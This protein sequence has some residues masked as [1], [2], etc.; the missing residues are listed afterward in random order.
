MPSFEHVGWLRQSQSS[1][2]RSSF[3]FITVV[4]SV[5]CSREELMIDIEDDHEIKSSQLI[6]FGGLLEDNQ[7][8]SL[9][10]ET[11]AWIWK[12]IIDRIVSCA[13]ICS[14]G[15]VQFYPL[16]MLFM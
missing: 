16:I 7:L 3:I 4:L 10:M 14:H 8:Y 9:N 13:I 5:S 15:R 11:L 12:G 2:L 6:V 1:I